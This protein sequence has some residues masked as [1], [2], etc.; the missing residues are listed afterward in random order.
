MISLSPEE[1]EKLSEEWL[2]AAEEVDWADMMCKAQLE[3]LHK[4][5]EEMCYD[6][7]LITLS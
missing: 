1:I 3:Q 7:T 2:E 6:H 4:W 5:G